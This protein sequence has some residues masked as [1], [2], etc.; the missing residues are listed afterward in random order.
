MYFQLVRG[1]SSSMK[2]V[3]RL[4]AVAQPCYTTKQILIM[5]CDAAFSHS[6][7][8]QNSNTKQYFTIQSCL[9][10]TIRD[11]LWEGF[12]LSQV[13]DGKKWG[14]QKKPCCW[15]AFASTSWRSFYKTSLCRSFFCHLTKCVLPTVKTA[16]TSNT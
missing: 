6:E 12:K 2:V 14:K 4:S 8:P 7:E 1:L 10:F 13:D 11:S 3:N 5:W 16:H 9:P 15:L